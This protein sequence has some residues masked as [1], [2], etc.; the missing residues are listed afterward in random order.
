[1]LQHGHERRGGNLAF[2]AEVGDT[3]HDIRQHSRRTVLRQRSGKPP[4]IR[5]ATLNVRN[6]LR[7]NTRANNNATVEGA[8][9]LADWMAEFHT[10]VLLV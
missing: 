1:M 2:F 5:V 7:P 3:G 4:V 9:N 8:T 6:L 10:D